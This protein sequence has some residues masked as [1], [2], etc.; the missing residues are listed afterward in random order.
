MN[1][2]YQS[3]I[4]VNE[5]DPSYLKPRPTQYKGV[6]FRSKSEAVFARCMDLAGALWVY[7]PFDGK[8]HSPGA[9]QWDFLSF[10]PRDR[11]SIAVY[12]NHC[13][14]PGIDWEEWEPWLIEYKPQRPTDAYVSDLQARVNQWS[15]TTYLA[16]DANIAIIFGSPWKSGYYEVIWLL[17][18]GKTP[19]REI[20]HKLEKLS[21]HVSSAL[22]YRFDLCTKNA[23]SFRYRYFKF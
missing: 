7:E 1:D 16:C 22:S 5:H 3:R 20:P 2:M 18:N 9:H 15:S 12:D 13:F 4:A 21:S 10:M 6:R 17:I 23:V 8:Q 14:F 19:P 11:T